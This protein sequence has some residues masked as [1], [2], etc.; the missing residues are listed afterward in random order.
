MLCMVMGK[1][2]F[3]SQGILSIRMNGSMEKVPAVRNEADMQ[4]GLALLDEMQ[5]I[6]STL[7]VLRNVGIME[8]VPVGHDGVQKR[9]V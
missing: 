9:M 1:N 2:S 3:N 5:A 6:G 8:E 4:R 7:S